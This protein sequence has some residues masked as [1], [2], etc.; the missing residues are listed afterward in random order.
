MANAEGGVDMI[1]SKLTVRFSINMDNVQKLAR[2]A[3]K[4]DIKFLRQDVN[5]TLEF[6]YVKLK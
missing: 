3:D 5:V 1:T 6:T 2:L 4:F